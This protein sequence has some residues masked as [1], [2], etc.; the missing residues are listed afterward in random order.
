MTK[1]RVAA[2]LE[3]ISRIVPGVAG[4]Q[5]RERRRDADKAVRSR[6][7]ASLTRC[8]NRLSDGMNEIS[9]AGGR[10]SLSMVGNL[11]RVNTRL[12]RI[13]DE[14]RYAPHGYA[15]WFDREGV[16]LEDLESLYEYDLSLLEIAERMAELVGSV[17]ALGSEK[18]W[19][20]DLGRELGA[21]R[22]ALDNRMSVIRGGE[23]PR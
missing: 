14:I 21:L 5:D 9:R 17:E 3:K 12:E 23:E 4:Y 7:V 16:A 20:Q 18:D 10:G 6:V 19:M 13:E 11:E 15:G 8:R 1:S 22:Q 2:L